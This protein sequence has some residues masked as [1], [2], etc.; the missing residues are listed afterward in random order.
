MK[1]RIV[2]P[3][4]GVLDNTI[5]EDRNPNKWEFV[6]SK[7]QSEGVWG[8]EF[9]IGPM[10]PFEGQ[11]ETFKIL[12]KKYNLHVI[13][14]LH[15]C[16]YPI[17]SRKLEDHIEWFRKYLREA[18]SWD[19]VFVNSHSGVDGWSFE[20]SVNFFQKALQIEK[21]EGILV[22]HET[23]RQRI[24]YNPWITRDILTKLP[25]LK[26]N[27]D[28]SHFVVVCERLLDDTLDPEWPGILELIAKRCFFIHARVGY[29]EGPQVPD[30]SA[31]EYSDALNAH[32]KWWKRIWS[33]QNT[34]N[35]SFAYVE[36]EFG[37][38]PY[39]H[40]LPHTNVPVA[41]LWK[42]NSW[43]ANRISNNY[44]FHDGE[45]IK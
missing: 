18:K 6:F 3:M 41:D 45:F 22:V 43:V 1:L 27:A 21:E 28:L 25:D 11:M 7:L 4:W 39:L 29:A 34:R 24:L 26:V 13:G 14:Q 42:I 36:P 2:R 30:P 16:S 15:T 17:H 32:E 23:H 8:I 10:N 20:E 44:F 40:T 35:D 12:L 19:A 31:N 5:A 9:V 38:A 37:P 33:I